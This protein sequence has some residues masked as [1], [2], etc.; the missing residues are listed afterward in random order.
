MRCE[1]LHLLSV[2]FLLSELSCPKYTVPLL[3]HRA[4][5]YPCLSMFVCPA[6]KGPHDRRC[7]FTSILSSMSSSHLCLVI[8][9]PN[10]FSSRRLLCLLC[11]LIWR[12]PSM[13]LHCLFASHCYRA[14]LFLLNSAFSWFLQSIVYILYDTH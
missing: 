14:C 11:L 9:P 3:P 5:L 7:N 10:P 1:L 8:I 13:S 12:S 2:T 4:Y 6:L